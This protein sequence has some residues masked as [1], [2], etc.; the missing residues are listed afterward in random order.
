MAARR[1]EVFARDPA[2]LL[3]QGAEDVRPHP[4]RRGIYVGTLPAEG[5]ARP[6]LQDPPP[7]PDDA[8]RL[9]DEVLGEAAVSSLEEVLALPEAPRPAAMWV[10][11]LGDGSVHATLEAASRWR[12]SLPRPGAQPVRELARGFEWRDLPEPARL[13]EVIIERV[14][15]AIDA[16][17]RMSGGWRA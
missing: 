10:R 8:D 13:G 6:V 4:R 1:R 7:A 5:D 14:K 11:C 17:P 15:V 12:A 9:P 2:Q 3:A 16:A